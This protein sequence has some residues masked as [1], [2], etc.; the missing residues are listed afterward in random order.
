MNEVVLM[1]G[2]RAESKRRRGILIGLAVVIVAAVIAFIL[3]RDC[4]APPPTANLPFDYFRAKAA[5][6]GNEPSKVLAFVRDDIGT[7]SYRGNAKG[8]LGTLWHGAGSP[9]EKL[10]LARALLE[11]CPDA[12]A[13]GLDD[14]APSRDKNA[15]SKTPPLTMKILLRLT[16]DGKPADET[17]F[18]GAIGDLIGDVQ[19]LAMGKD[20]KAVLTIRGPAATTRSVA[21]GGAAAGDLVFVIQRPETEKPCTIIRELWHKDNRVGPRGPL[22]DDRHDF[23]VWPCRITPYVREKEELRLVE[24][25]RIPK[26]PK[27]MP[28]PTKAADELPADAK[29][30]LAL[31]DYAVAADD[32]LAGLEQDRQVTAQFDLP[33]ILILSHFNVPDSVSVGGMYAFDLRLNRPGFA[34][35]DPASAYSAT[36]VRS[37]IESGLEQHYLAAWTGMPATS[38]YDVINRMREGCPNSCDRRAGVIHAALSALQQYGAAD[39]RVVFA[40]RDASGEATTGARVTVSRPGSGFHLRSSALRPA[41]VTDWQSREKDLAFTDGKLDCEIADLIAAGTAVETCLMAAAVRPETP[42]GFVLDTDIQLGAEP[43]VVRNASFSFRWGTGE[44]RTEQDILIRSTRRRLSYDWRVQTGIRPVAGT[45]TL[46]RAELESATVHNPWYRQGKPEVDKASSF[47]VSREV[48]R[49]LKAGRKVR[50][51]FLGRYGLKDDEDGPRPVA[52]DGDVTPTGTGTHRVEI[53]GKMETIPLLKCR[54]G[55]DEVAILDD[56]TFPIGMAD[57][58][59]KITTAYRLRVVDETGMGIA[60]AR[61]SLK[62]HS[63]SHQAGLDG[64]LRLLPD[65]TRPYGKEVLEVELD[66]EKLGE[67]TVDFTT[68]GRTEVEIKVKRPVQELVWISKSNQRELNRLKVSDQVKRHVTRTIAAGRMALIPRR[69]VKTGFGETIGYYAFDQ[70]TGYI[71]GV[72]ETGLNGSGNMAQAW[73]GALGS[74]AGDLNDSKGDMGGM[75][76]IHMYRGALTA[77]WTYCRYRMQGLNNEETIIRLL[78]EMDAWEAYTNMLT[79]VKDWGGEKLHGKMQ[80]LMNSGAANTDGAGAKAAFKVGYMQSTAFLG[81]YMAGKDG[82]Q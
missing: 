69:M 46:E 35:A 80:E 2:V 66:D 5:E 13:A 50:M 37:F 1:S 17:L 64:R 8:A 82:A 6:L 27:G 11:H 55:K 31:L 76:P 29:A 4:K 79:G 32:L 14:V 43:L 48:Y 24:A 73:G 39:A 57:K 10:A 23:V 22:P 25:D 28:S 12:A 21:T 74:L 20:G 19:T 15:D 53:N 40:A 38:A 3:L 75:G 47:V 36:E 59:V 65:A 68:L 54:I 16:R 60:S 9:E 77:W 63:G 78:T 67:Q 72:T 7:L 26:N 30:Y 44:R 41:F 33:R 56:P 58:L 42:P 81:M 62:Q 51:K 45:R 18:E 49:Q 71:V 52:W 70:Q 34:G 61:V